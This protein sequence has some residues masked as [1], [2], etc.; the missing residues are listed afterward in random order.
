[1][2]Y[3]YRTD[4]TQTEATVLTI[5]YGQL[6]VILHHEIVCPTAIRYALIVLTPTIFE[7]TLISPENGVAW[8]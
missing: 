6:K 5:E 8:S 3:F 4:N 7:L 1:M 2:Q